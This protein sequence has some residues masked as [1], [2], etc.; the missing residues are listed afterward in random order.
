MTEPVSPPSAATVRIALRF[1]TDLQA[2]KQPLIEVA[3][4]STPRTEWGPLLHSLLI[5][6]VNARRGRGETPL[7]REY[8]PRFPAHTDVVRA[9]VPESTGASSSLDTVRMVPVAR[10]PARESSR[11]ARASHRHR[12]WTVVGIALV[13]ATMAALLVPTRRPTTRSTGPAAAPKSM[14]PS[15]GRPNLLLKLP[16]NDPER[17]LAEW[18]TAIG[19]RGTL[20]LSNGG[21]RTFG[22]EVLLPKESFAVTGVSLPPEAATLWAEDDLE[23][24]RGRTKLTSLRLYHAAALTDAAL[25]PLKDLPLISL[26][27][28]GTARVSGRTLASFQKLESL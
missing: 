15:A 28:H 18:V 13:A 2:G 9:V 25:K 19:G 20:V 24:L 17:D 11:S 26:E 7:L 23:R 27:L 16:T 8:L 22:E 12:W 4:D 10:P 21:R 1:A 14:P 3:L 5:A 6:E